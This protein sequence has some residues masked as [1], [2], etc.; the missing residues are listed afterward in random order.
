MNIAYVT[1]EIEPFAR[2]GGLGD[3]MGALPKSMEKLGHRVSLFMPLYKHIDQKGF[4]VNPTRMTVAV[5]MPDR[6][7]LGLVY[8][9]YVPGTRIPVYFIE[10]KGYF[11]RKELYKDPA[12]GKDY[13]DNCERF[14]FFSRAV[15]ETMKALGQP[16]DILHAHE[17]QAALAPTYLKTLYR[18]DA[19]F[20][21]TL[22]VFTIH[23]LAHQG[24]FPKEDMPFTG[25]D[26]SYFN[27]R[28]L[29]YYGQ[30][31]LLK[32]GIV[33]ADLVTTVSR[34]YAQEI[35]TEEYGRGMEGVLQER[36]KDLFGIVNGVDYEVWNPEKDKFIASR[37]GLKNL[38]GKKACK[39]HLQRKCGLEERDVPVIGWI[40][41]LVEQKGVDLLVEVWEEMMEL[42]LEFILLGTGDKPY[43]EALKEKASKYPGKASINIGFDNCLSHEIE[44][45]AD[46]FLMP[47]KF[48][49]CGLNQL[50]SLKYGTVPIVRR[51]GGLVDTV[52]EQVGFTFNSASASEMLEAVKR[53]V[54]AYRNSSQWTELVRRGMLQ[55]WSWE[56][57]GLEYIKLYREGL[58]RKRATK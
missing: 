47:S 13:K 14:A 9:T 58:N 18:D 10:N 7:S 37:Y 16:P 54:V 57:S 17:W 21:N 8:L 52:D 55:D 23:N 42:D 53:A 5:P 3:V 25:L 49:P 41:R 4:S 44:A 50:Y 22:T 34:Q 38:E 32:T 31:N 28:Q 51:T 33:F 36:S 45:G 30:I 56:H 6:T 46:M 11:E 15:L 1:P 29:E 26:M 27:L 39:G 19:F 35:Q 24:L 43:E 48:E 40:G 12:T 20:K 2:T